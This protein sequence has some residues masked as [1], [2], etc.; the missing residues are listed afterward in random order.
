M[1][2]PDRSSTAPFVQGLPRQVAALEW[3]LV[4]AAVLLFVVPSPLFRRDPPGVFGL[5]MVWA[6]L[7]VAAFR[8]RWLQA[9]H[10]VLLAGLGAVAYMALPP[11]WPRLVALAVGL[12][13][14]AL[15]VRGSPWLR[16]TASWL[17]RGSVDAVVRWLILATAPVVALAL[18]GWAVAVGDA[19]LS[20]GAR[21]AIRTVEDVPLWLLVPGAVAFSCANAAAEEAYFRGAFMT[22]LLATTGRVPAL[23]LQA[24]SYGL[25]HTGGFPS[26]ALG[27]ALAT[28]YGLVLGIVR[29]RSGGLLAPWLAHVLADLTIMALI[30][31]FAAVSPAV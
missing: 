6:A 2:Q 29:L 20:E 1:S 16:S 23:L 3:L 9:A 10:V 19:G 17:R 4:V 31:W 24:V 18:T 8:L 14:Y 11:L 28:V 26:G 7:V 27:V 15:L 13:A 12:G 21:L 30:A 22:A 5:A 25:L